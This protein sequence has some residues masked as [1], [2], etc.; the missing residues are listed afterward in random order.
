MPQL[1]RAIYGIKM[2]QR[3]NFSIREEDIEWICV[4]VCYQ[5][6][7][8]GRQVFLDD[9]MESKALYD[10][11]IKDRLYSATVNIHWPTHLTT[12]LDQS[13][14]I[15]KILGIDR[16]EPFVPQRGG[17]SLVNPNGDVIYVSK[18]EAEAFARTVPSTTLGFKGGNRL[19]YLGRRNGSILDLTQNI[20]D[21]LPPR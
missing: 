14:T 16:I 2:P 7:S 9:I 15:T 6:F 13:S 10:G 21:I 1:D 4:D 8:K 18:G 3:T 20:K 5:C 19:H 12:R 17:Y 11:E